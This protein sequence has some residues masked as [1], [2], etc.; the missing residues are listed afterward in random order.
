MNNIP[1]E[2]L[3][4][5]MKWRNFPREKPDNIQ[6]P[7]LG[8]ESV[9]D[10]PRPL[11]V[12]PVERRILVE[13]NGAI[14][15]KT[16]NAFRVIETACPPVLPLLPV[17]WMIVMWMTIRSS[18][19]PVTIMVV[20]SRQKSWDHLRV[21]PALNAGNYWFYRLHRATHESYCDYR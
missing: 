5:V 17:R 12:E 21:T 19:N 18:L 15:A 11:R 2:L 1:D 3:E 9:W 7:E 14:I 8:Q 13:F 16:R 6:V 10:Y 20:G 4:K